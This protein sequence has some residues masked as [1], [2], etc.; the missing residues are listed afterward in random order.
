VC[1]IGL[2]VVVL[3]RPPL[4]FLHLCLSLVFFFIGLY[5]ADFVIFFFWC[6]CVSLP[7]LYLTGF[8]LPLYVSLR[9]LSPS[10]AILFSYSFIEPLAY[11]WI[12]GI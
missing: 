9:Y 2:C 5:Y 3:H 1:V 12:G 10:V 7:T 6:V 11:V 4:P 8:S